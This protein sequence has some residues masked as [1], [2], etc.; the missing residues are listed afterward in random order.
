MADAALNQAVRDLNRVH[1]GRNRVIADL[2]RKQA[3]K[4]AEARQDG[5]Q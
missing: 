2:N 3:G 5:G 4:L 1:R